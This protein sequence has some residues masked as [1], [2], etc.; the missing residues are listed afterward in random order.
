MLES[1]PTRL[2]ALPVRKAAETDLDALVDLLREAQRWMNQ[3]N[4]P[5]WVPGAHNSSII[6]NF[7]QQE[8]ACVV[9]Y[10]GQVI[11]TCVLRD[12]LPTHWTPKLQPVGYLSTLTVARAFAGSGIGAAILRWEEE[13]MRQQGKI[14]AC[15]DCCAKNPA[16]CAYYERQGYIAVGEV[17]TYPGYAERMFQKRLNAATGT[18]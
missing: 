4:L 12:M 17:E 15:L 7:I 16:L 1:I 3:R 18:S 14:W 13:T 5:Q 11:A 6:E 10:D 2:G 8:N 9:L